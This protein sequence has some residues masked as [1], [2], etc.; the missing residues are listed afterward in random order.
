MQGTPWHVVNGW[1]LKEKDEF[2]W[3]VKEIE[4]SKN[5][6]NV[7]FDVTK[8][9]IKGSFVIKFDGDDEKEYIIGK[10]ISKNAALVEKIYFANVG[11]ILHINE[12][13][14]TILKK[15]LY[16]KL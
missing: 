9:N 16:I 10:N 12:E 5:K 8:Q 11:D 3:E 4:Q 2:A 14:V 15:N 1:Q 7:K 13:K 6:N